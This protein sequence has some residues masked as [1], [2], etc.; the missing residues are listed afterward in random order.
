MDLLSNITEFNNIGLLILRVGIAVSFLYHGI[1]KLKMW[2]MEPS[3]EMP[4][5]MLKQ[6]RLLS[7]VEPLGAVALVS[8]F[9]TQLAAIGFTIIMLGAINLKVGQMQKKFGEP[10]GWELDVVL[11][12]GCIAL[13]LTGAGTLSFDYALWGI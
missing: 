6:L 1:D 8:G 5:S 13:V 10:G 7:I 4:A 11:M 3:E 2:K 9:L 12:A